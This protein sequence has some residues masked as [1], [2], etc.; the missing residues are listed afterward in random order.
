[1]V[2]RPI[3]SA[4]RFFSGE[5]AKQAAEPWPAG[6]A[7]VLS[8]AYTVS[9]DGAKELE[10]FDNQQ[11]VMYDKSKKTERGKYLAVN[12]TWG[13]DEITKLYTVTLNGES[14]TYS[15]AEPNG[16]T[17]MLVKGDFSAAN[18][19]ES[20]IATTYNGSDNEA[21]PEAEITAH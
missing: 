10:L 2:K 17:C 5:D 18:L 19:R 4:R 8:C 3:T 16:G 20:W 12:G 14:A 13:F 6:W 21:P 15:I 11:V 1:M 7:D 9:F